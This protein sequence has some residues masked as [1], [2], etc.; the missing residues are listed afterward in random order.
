MGV[1]T[2]NGITCVSTLVCIAVGGDTVVENRKRR[3]DVGFPP[4][5]SRIADRDLMWGPQPASLSEPSPATTPS[6]PAASPTRRRIVERGVEQYFAGLFRAG[7]CAC[8]AQARCEVIGQQTANGAQFGQIMGSTDGGSG[9][10]VQYKLVGGITSL[11]GIA[12]PTPTV[13]EVVG[14]SLKTPVLSTVDGGK[15]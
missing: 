10:Q 4:A 8:S 5:R 1:G 15:T 9:W 14:G 11:D 6:A 3:A 13:C 7:R 2:L 12:C